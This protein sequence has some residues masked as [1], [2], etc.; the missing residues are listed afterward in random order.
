MVMRSLY[1]Y[2]LCVD[3]ARLSFCIQS[4]RHLYLGEKQMSIAMQDNI[5]KDQAVNHIH[6]EPS[7]R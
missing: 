3:M 6:L 1:V 2:E 4:V 7:L 5:K